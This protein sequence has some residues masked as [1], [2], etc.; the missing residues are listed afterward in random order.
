MAL[1]KIEHLL[2]THVT[3]LTYP[4]VPKGADEIRFQVAATQTA[5]D[6]EQVIETLKHF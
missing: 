1:Q 3:G 2:T 5:Q 4:V 6:I